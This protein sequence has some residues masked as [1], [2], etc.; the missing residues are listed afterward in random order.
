MFYKSIKFIL[1]QDSAFFRNLIAAAGMMLCL[2][3]YSFAQGQ[4]AATFRWTT[5]PDCPLPTVNATALQKAKLTFGYLTVPENRH[6]DNG[7]VLKLAV[8]LI[9]ATDPGPGQTPLIILHGGPG[10]RIVPNVSGP[11]ALLR[12]DRDIIEIDQRGSGYSE[13][14]LSPEMNQEIADLFARDLSDS[15][16]MEARIAMAASARAKLVAQGIDLSAYNSEEIAADI[17]DLCRLLGYKSFDLWGASYGTRIALTM[18][19][20][21]P[22]GI[23]SVV[24]ELPLP[25]NVKYFQRITTNFKR[26]LFKLFDE[27]AA[28]PSCR[29]AYPH[30]KGDFYAAIDS[31]DKRPIVIPMKDGG[32]Y[33]DGKF[34]INSQDMLLGFQQA[35]YGKAAYPIMPL[36]VEAVKDRNVNEL[37]GFVESMSNGISRLRYGTYYSVI[38]NECM[39]FNSLKA[40]EDSSAGFWNGLTFYKDEFGICKMWNPNMPDSLDSAAVVSNIPVLILSGDLDPIAPP[41]NGEVAKRTLPHAWMYTFENTGHL[42]STDDHAI[43]L[44]G[45]FLADP[46]REP[47][48]VHFVKTGDIPFATNV[49]VHSGIISLA[50]RLRWNKSNMLYNYWM[51]LIVI[52]LVL[53][54]FFSV[55][56][57]IVVRR[58]RIYYWSAMLSAVFSI[59]FIAGLVMAILRTA[60]QNY[61]LLGFGLPQRY[62]GILIFPYLIFLLFIVQLGLLAGKGSNKA[63]KK[64]VLLFLL[65]LPFVLFVCWF[66][67]FY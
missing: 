2:S 35:L 17:H 54:L 26:S 13:P 5:C 63:R 3:S 47:D 14:E 4:S 15:A 7:R 36:L 28:D 22:E 58:E 9:K 53:N 49:H 23:R 31:L 29:L 6:K 55:R 64:K 16:E 8:A 19:R 30:L 11:Y 45:K 57:L 39:P 18:M 51:V 60:S 34:V 40:F 50:P 32:G 12:K 43:Q 56:E 42:V 24:L 33:P 66:G 27:C 48:S 65:D 61:F 44:I 25:P 21:Y 46:S 37:R 20:D 38:C 67:L 59:L 41:A 10:G 1:M 62:S 52:A